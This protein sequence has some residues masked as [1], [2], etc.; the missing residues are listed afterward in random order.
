MCVEGLAGRRPGDLEQMLSGY[1]V[2]VG[3][4]RLRGL[5]CAVAT[6]T[7]A[8]RTKECFPMACCSQLLHLGGDKDRLALGFGCGL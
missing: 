3:L 1:D 2:D 4:G 6:V 7:A 5:A 8:C